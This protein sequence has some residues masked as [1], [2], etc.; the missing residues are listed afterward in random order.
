[1]L[2]Y[3]EE[4]RKHA[5]VPK[6]EEWRKD[7]TITAVVNLFLNLETFRDSWDDDDKVQEALRSPYFTQLGVE[8]EDHST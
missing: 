2:Q 6:L 3:F 8:L 4:Y 1:M 7:L 5:G